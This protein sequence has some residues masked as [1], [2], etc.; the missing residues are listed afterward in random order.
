VDGAEEYLLPFQFYMPLLKSKS[1]ESLHGEKLWT[2]EGT[3]ATDHID[4]QGEK[5]I[6]RG[7]DFKPFL[8]SGVLNWD[9]G[10]GPEDILGEP[11][12]AKVIEKSQKPSIFWVKGWLYKHQPRAQAVW[13]HLQA[14]EKGDQP[15]TRKVGWSV[16]GGVLERKGNELI[17]SIVRHV[18]LTHQP[19]NANTFA[20]C[21]SSLAKSLQGV[22][23]GPG[24]YPPIGQQVSDLRPL[25]PQN[26][27]A[28]VTS[29]IYVPCINGCFD[30]KSKEFRN[31]Y[32]GM[33]DHL[34][35]CKG[36]PVPEAKQFVM[37]M[38]QQGAHL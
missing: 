11:L 15:I 34:A 20:K 27:D 26:L 17:K 23:V 37:L 4:Q 14:L 12:D 13:N 18:A 24:G 2:V 28:T 25:T 22:G 1:A 7:M 16:Q 35:L 29:L 21:M 10:S 9:H 19:V 30:E 31:G 33:L 6:L 5:L 3:A 38:A 36:V 32:H 8:K